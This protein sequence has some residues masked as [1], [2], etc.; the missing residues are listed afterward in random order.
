MR[1]R[2]EEHSDHR[3]KTKCGLCPFNMML[4]KVNGANK[5]RRRKAAVFLPEISEG[6][7]RVLFGVSADVDD[8]EY[9]GGGDGV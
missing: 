5:R 4:C 3:F 1:D 7:C 9:F 2:V 6:I 8:S